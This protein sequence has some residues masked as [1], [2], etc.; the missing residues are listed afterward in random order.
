MFEARLEHRGRRTRLLQQALGE[1]RA[2]VSLNA[3][4]LER[5]Y[6]YTKNILLIRYS[7][8]MMHVFKNRYNTV[9]IF[10]RYIVDVVFI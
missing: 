6:K 5:E 7:L 9:F 4:D 8:F 2:I 1:L 3:F 10:R